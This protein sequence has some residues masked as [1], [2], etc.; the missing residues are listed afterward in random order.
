M[1][2]EKEAKEFFQL[3]QGVAAWSPRLPLA[4]LPLLPSQQDVLDEP[5]ACFTLYRAWGYWQTP[6]PVS[7]SGCCVQMLWHCTHRCHAAW[8]E[9]QQY[10]CHVCGQRL[11]PEHQQWRTATSAQPHGEAELIGALDVLPKGPLPSWIVF[12]PCVGN[13]GSSGLETQ[14]R[15]CFVHCQDSYGEQKPMEL[16]SPCWRLPS[17]W[18]H[19][20]KASLGSHK[21]HSSLGMPSSFLAHSNIST[22][23]G[24]ATGFETPTKT[25]ME[26][27]LY[28][29]VFVPM[30]CCQPQLPPGHSAV[31]LLTFHRGT[32]GKYTKESRFTL[33]NTLSGLLAL[34]SPIKS[35]H[36]FPP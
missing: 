33:P 2:E 24:S 12:P 1:Y 26:E 10:R 16:A 18:Q 5:Q 29:V 21:Y 28:P 31:S 17:R 3:A 22:A 34:F 27:V 11:K 8:G 14:P 6:L 23:V 9:T 19:K 13:H 20:A 4:P 7:S 15:F 36:K 30:S 32:Q 35:T 25:Q